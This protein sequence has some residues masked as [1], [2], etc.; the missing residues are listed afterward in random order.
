M[1]DI[2]VSRTAYRFTDK[3]H[4]EHP[5]ALAQL[6]NGHPYD[7]S[8]NIFERLPQVFF[9]KKPADGNNYIQ[10]LGRIDNQRVLKYVRR[11]YIRNVQNLD[12]YKIFLSKANGTGAFG[13]TLT[14]PIVG[15]PSVGNTET[16]I[17]IGLFDSEKEAKALMKYVCTKFARA[18]LGAL[19]TTQDITPEKWKYVP[20]QD[21]SDNSDI[22]W[23]L[24][25]DEIDEFLYKKYN[26]SPTEISFIKENVQTMK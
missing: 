20:Q 10:I 4:E 1:S 14:P 9:D 15:A 13:E 19:K 5:E 22:D 2:T 6:S 26:L 17:S 8:T 11:D 16:F 24:P 21:F 7:V 18:L 12:N 23:S 25:I 3:M